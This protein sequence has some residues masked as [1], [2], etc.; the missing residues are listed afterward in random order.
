M[1]ESA[2]SLIDGLVEGVEA[3]AVVVPA[4]LKKPALLLYVSDQEEE[5]GMEGAV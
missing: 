1:L 5:Q 3:F 2:S 4:G